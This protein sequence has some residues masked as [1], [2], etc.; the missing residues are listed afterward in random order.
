MLLT[1]LFG[2]GALIMVVGAG[3]ACSS[4]TYGG[5][6]NTC[7]M[8][9]AQVCMVSS[10]FSPATLTVSAG[11]TVQWVNSDGYAHTV[12]SDPGSTE[13][14]NQ[15]VGGSG[16]FSYKFNTAGTFAYHCTIHGAPGSGMHGTIKVN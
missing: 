15:S 14:F 13:T 9:A 5:G 3:A 4:S 6:T 12:T 2:A 1:R 7:T 11:T 10:T 16:T 8:A